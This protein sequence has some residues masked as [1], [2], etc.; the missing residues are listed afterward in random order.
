M[1]HPLVDFLFY[2]VLAL[3]VLGL[4]AVGIV[5]MLVFTIVDAA[6]RALGRLK[7]VGVR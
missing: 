2:F 4:L 1:R 6:S 5:A 7:R 3:L